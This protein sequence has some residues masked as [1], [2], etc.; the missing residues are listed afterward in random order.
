MDLANVKTK[1]VFATASL[2]K[3]DNCTEVIAT[4]KNKVG[5]DIHLLSGEQEAKA[6]FNS[7]KDTELTTDDGIVIDLGGGSC[8]VINFIN[9][10]VITSESMLSV[11]TH[12]TAIMLVD[13]FRMIRK[14][15]Q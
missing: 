10:T 12:A 8:E 11:H 6:S 3:I 13:C 2:R 4:V 14:L 7:V 1:Y 15:M 5:L 9:K